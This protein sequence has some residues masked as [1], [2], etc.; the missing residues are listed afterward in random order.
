MGL[1]QDLEAV[2]ELSFPPYRGF[3]LLGILPPDAFF[4]SNAFSLSVSLSLSLPL[5]LERTLSLVQVCTG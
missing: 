2:S 3:I 5:S 1:P 4:F